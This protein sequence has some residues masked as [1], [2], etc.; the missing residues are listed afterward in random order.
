MAKQTILITGGTGFLGKHLA[1]MLKE[2]FNVVLGGRNNKHNRDAEQATGCAALPLDVTNIESVRDV[3]TE[4]R[5]A[6]VVHAAATKYVDLSERQPLE[7]LDVNILGSQNVARVSA[8]RG[9]ETVIGMST[10]KAAPPVGNTYGMTKALMERVFCAMNGKTETRFACVRHGNIAW[11]TGSV[12]PIWRR[13][14]ET[15]GG[16]IGST[17]PDMTRYFSSV[18]EAAELVV[19]AID[20]VERVQG[21]VLSRAMKAARIRDI[22][23]LWVKHKGGSW[24]QIEGR[25]G[26]RPHEYLIG[27]PELLYTSEAEFGGVRHY[28]ISFN[29]PQPRPLARVLC[30]ADAERLSDEE[31]LEIINNPPPEELL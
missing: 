12:F 10:D 19:T 20:N 14:Q 25:P 8:E 29:E 30:S 3:F 28:V 13:M 31:V 16:V 2:R 1:L 6:V 11:S 4:S 22:L 7:C 27:E 15:N 5:P 9:V 24:H 18:Q 17:G 26:E 23:E 21:R